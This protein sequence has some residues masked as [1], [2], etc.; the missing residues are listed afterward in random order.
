VKVSTP[1]SQL[2]APKARF[3]ERLGRW[4]L[5][6]WVA[7]GL[8]LLI[9]LV[10]T[11][12]LAH[13][14]GRDVAWDLGDSLLNMWILAWDAEQLT[15]IF[16][17]DLSRIRTFFD[18]NIFYP[19]ARTLAYS[20]HLF[21]QAVQVFPV[22][23]ASGNPILCYN[24][25][26]LSTFVLCGLGT[27]LLVRELT[28]N[29]PA[30]F[31]AGLLF[32]FAPYR[33]AQVS[34]LQVLSV[35]W[36]PFVLYGL[37]RYFDSRRRQALA[38]AAAALVAQNLSCIYYLLYFAPLAGLYAAWEIG[39]RRLWR[40]RG[41]WSEMGIAAMVVAVCTLP[42]VLPY[43]HV[44]DALGLSRDLPEIVRYSADVYSYWTA[45]AANEA[46]GDAIRAFPKPEGELF[47]GFVPLI[48]AA[49]AI[50]TTSFRPK[51]ALERRETH[52]NSVVVSGFSRNATAAILS[53]VATAHLALA[54]LALYWRRVDVDL[55]FFEIQATN[56]TRLFVIALVAFGAL[57]AISPILRMRLR[58]ALRRPET[59]FAIVAV[60]A[61]WLS[62]GPSPRVYGRLLD[63]WAPYAL[64][65]E[66]VPGY[67]GV[68]VPARHAMI[69]ALA[70]AVLGGLFVVRVRRHAAI[71]VAVLSA[72]FL[73]ETKVSRFRVNAVSPV[74]SFATPEARV[75]RPE[76]APAIYHDVADA[77]PDAVVLE[78]PFGEPDYDLRAV[79][80]STVHWKKVVNGYSGFFPPHYSRLIA[81]LNAFERDDDIAWRTL[82]ALEVT[83]V[84]VHE[85][86]YLTDEGA[87][88]SAWLAAHG[89]A[90]VSRRDRDVLFELPH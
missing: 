24:L 80:Y 51:G 65:F 4:K 74:A 54:L 5:T 1:K 25:L 28:S 89:A 13:G 20:E 87:R 10:M 69:V 53:A 22:Y 75:Y 32:A 85:G 2:P 16:A 37:R 39:T 57:V 11:W 15:A 46:W 40:E 88:F 76:R 38:G 44:R 43:K 70:L 78:M 60:S 30:A 26:F 8:Y 66:H 61:W 83:H 72:M 71:A 59:I 55:L 23:V 52:S 36:M 18:A 41:M 90:E 47:P 33:F 73:L 79:Y 82:E 77:H 29:A 27:F 31:L 68:R 14:I 19:E 49:A 64:V 9:T 45:F 12:P 56:V 62:L 34:H 67:D 7:T 50:V 58:A 3:A 84:I 48:L 21:A 42:F 63:L 6:P 17:G 81:L 86:A 35:Q